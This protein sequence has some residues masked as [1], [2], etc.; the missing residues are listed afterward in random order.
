MNAISAPKV[1]K[2]WLVSDLALAIASGRPWLGMDCVPREVLILDNEL[3][4][5]TSANRIPKVAERRG[6]SVRY[7]Q[8]NRRELEATGNANKGANSDAN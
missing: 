7:V 1:G 2:S 4:G 5:E 3:H 8:R 6:V